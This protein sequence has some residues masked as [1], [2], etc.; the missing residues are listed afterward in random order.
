MADGAVA[1]ITPIGVD[2]AEFLGT[3]VTGIAR[4]KAGII[5]PGAVAVLA[6]QEPQ[7][8]AVLLERCVEVDAQVAREGSEFE[9][10]SRE[11]AIGG[12]RIVLRGLGGVVDD[13]FLPLHGEHQ[14]ANAALALAAAEALTGAGPRQPIDPDAIRAAFAGVS[15]PG[16]LSGWPPG[17]VRRRCS[18][19]PRTTRTGPAPWPPR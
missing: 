10:L 8:A 6:A 12:Q 9:V 5:K 1:V 2:H 17:P 19:T 14:A 7:V 11:V 3:D 4:E 15:S 16:G 18:P 13:I